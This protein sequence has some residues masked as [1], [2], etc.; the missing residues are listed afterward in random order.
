MD[1][2]ISLVYVTGNRIKF[3]VATQVMSQSGID[4]IQA[5]LQVPEI[6][7]PDVEAVV[8]HSAMRAGQHLDQPFVITDAGFYIDALNGFPGPF[9]RYVNEWFSAQ[10][11]LNLM[12]GKEKRRVIVRDCLA[13]CFP[14]EEP[15]IFSQVHEG[16]LAA[17]AG[18][19]I[20]T[21]MDQ[22]F[23]PSDC[24]VPISE[25]SAEQRLAFWTRTSVWHKLKKHLAA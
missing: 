25:M 15:V 11:Y 1:R 14:T 23:I 19:E 9:I 12:D 4:L 13:Y 3:Q 18:R 24:M 16:Q 21:S 5:N 6:Q 22:L 7:S 20:G 10:D 2:K 17:R 8:M